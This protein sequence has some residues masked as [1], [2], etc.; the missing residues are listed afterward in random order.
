MNAIKVTSDSKLSK[1]SED[2][3]KTAG[4]DDKGAILLLK[5]LEGVTVQAGNISMNKPEVR[6]E[7]AKM[8]SAVKELIIRGLLEQT[9]EDVYQI[10]E[11]GYSFLENYL[12]KRE[13]V[14]L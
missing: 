6:R 8:I 10:T 2:I 13:G 11:S 3:L 4:K 9:G 12:F 14:V 7:E 1:E 5:D